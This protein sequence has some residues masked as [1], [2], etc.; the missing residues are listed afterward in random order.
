MEAQRK[1]VCFYFL[2]YGLSQW[3][4]QAKASCLCSKHF[5]YFKIGLILLCL[6]HAWSR[7][8]AVAGAVASVISAYTGVSKVG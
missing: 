5:R 4:F 7:G 6:K 1:L 3:E 2:S 8:V